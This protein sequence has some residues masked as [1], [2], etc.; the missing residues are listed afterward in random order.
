MELVR[1][2]CGLIMPH[3]SQVTPIAG[4]SDGGTQITITGTN[5][6]HAPSDIASVSVGSV[7]CTVNTT[8]YV[9]GT[10]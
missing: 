9:P 2:A 8:L 5:L 1:G 10:R 4:P 6:G 7:G 3:P